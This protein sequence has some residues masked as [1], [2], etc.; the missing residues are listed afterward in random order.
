MLDSG[1]DG[2]HDLSPAYTI[3]HYLLITIHCVYCHLLHQYIHACMCD[4]FLSLNRFFLCAN[5][6]GHSP[7]DFWGE[8]TCC[9]AHVFSPGSVRDQSQDMELENSCR[10]IIIQIYESIVPHVGPAFSETRDPASGRCFDSFRK[11]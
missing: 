6:G 10:N 7:S 5:D 8:H 2:H 9:L 4:L 11:L 3:K 1:P